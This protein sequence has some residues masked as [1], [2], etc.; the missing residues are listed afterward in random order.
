M[1]TKR[2]ELHK[3]EKI[4]SALLVKKEESDARK[5]TAA[6][7]AE[8]ESVVTRLINSGRTTDEIPALL[9]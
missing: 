3:A 6:K 8:I 7:K 1:K 4:L 2:K 5:S 9:K